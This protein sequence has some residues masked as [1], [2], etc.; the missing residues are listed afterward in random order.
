MPVPGVVEQLADRAAGH[1]AG[2]WLRVFVGHAREWGASPAR[3]SRLFKPDK[4]LK[5]RM[6]PGMYLGVICGQTCPTPRR[7]ESHSAL[8]DYAIAFEFHDDIHSGW[9]RR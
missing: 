3:S 2:P 5:V 4:R 6:G 8:D 7:F 9:Q 1:R